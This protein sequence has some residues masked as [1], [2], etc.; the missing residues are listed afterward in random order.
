MSPAAMELSMIVEMTSCTPRADLSSPAM[1]PHI[2]PPRTPATMAITATTTPGADW[3]AW[4]EAAAQIAPTMSWPC[5]PMLNSP[6]RSGMTTARPH[7]ISGTI[8]S[9]VPRRP[10]AVPKE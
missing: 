6:T 8:F 5:A 1:D 7:R 10:S 3:T 2:A 4:A 9:N